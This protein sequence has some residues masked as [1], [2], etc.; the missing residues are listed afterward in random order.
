[1]LPLDRWNV[2]VLTTASIVLAAVIYIDSITEWTMMLFYL[3]PLMAVAWLARGGWWLVIAL[4]TAALW[5]VTRYYAPPHDAFTPDGHRESL[6]TAAWNTSV[7][8]GI[9]LVVGVLC[10]RLRKFSRSPDSLSSSH[11]ATGLLSA[12]GLREAMRRRSTAERA[13]SGPV[14][15]LLLDVE[16][17]ISAYGGQSTEH[18][19][20]AGAVIGKTLLNHARAG[21]LC[22]RLSPNHFLVIMLNTDKS[23]AS[24]LNAAV[25]DALPEITRSLDDTVSVSS[26][27]LFSAAPCT[28][29]DKM[30]A[31][32][33][34]RLITLKVLGLGRNHTEVWP[35]TAT[36]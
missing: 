4:A 2:V 31:H 1:M 25:L 15:M 9:L 5:C 12:T 13:A 16:R 34:N 8:L 36:A 3:V 28:S 21:D 22:V 30:R 29:L 18:A 10:S 35:P 19:A 20:L 32:A 11:D 23:L 17:K 24:T 6:S 26:L 33:E 14:A 27:M 7:R